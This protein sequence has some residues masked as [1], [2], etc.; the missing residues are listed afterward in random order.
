M[1]G[2][3]GALLVPVTATASQV[4]SHILVCTKPCQIHTR[5]SDFLPYIPSFLPL[6]LVGVVPRVERV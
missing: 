5:S 2:A 1:D 6:F 4:Y 3:S